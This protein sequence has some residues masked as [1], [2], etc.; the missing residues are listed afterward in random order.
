LRLRGF[1]SVILLRI[2]QNFTFILHRN[3]KMA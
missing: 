2:T 3:K 1:L